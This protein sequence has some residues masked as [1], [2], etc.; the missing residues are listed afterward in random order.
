MKLFV[1]SDI[2]GHYTFMREALDA[3][4]FDKENEEH[5]LIC[6]GDYF[7]RGNEN[8]EVLQYFERLKRKVL[9]RGNHEDMLLKLLENGRVLD[10]H[11]IN[12]T[13]AT[14]E[15]FFGKYFIDPA[16]DTIDFSGK[17]R[18]VDRICDFIY[19]TVDFYETEKYLF[20][21]G[22]VP[23]GCTSAKE[24]KSAPT[25]AWIKARETRWTAK[26]EGEKPLSDKELICGDM[27]TFYAHH[28]DP[29]SRIGSTEIFFGNGLIAIDGATYD[30]KRVNV[31]VLDEY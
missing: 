27:P 1:V 17:T 23:A 6:C 19:D 18:T 25:E 12:G 7:D 26:Y 3:A 29:S 13:F 9:L 20:V 15:N 4:G 28:F 8:V 31:L 30:T 5:F 2:H 11:Y 10:H 16:N 22:W 24:A 14:L 21:H